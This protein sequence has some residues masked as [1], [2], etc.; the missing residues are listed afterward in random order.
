MEN[1]FGFHDIM[2]IH[3]E[4]DA[5]KGYERDQR[6]SRSGQ[7]MCYNVN[8]AHTCTFVIY[9]FYIYTFLTSSIFPLQNATDSPGES[10]QSHGENTWCITYVYDYYSF[11]CGQGVKLE[12]GC[13]KSR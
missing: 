8:T 1:G 12:S 11:G 10:L 9:M 3:S 6:A 5:T 7:L 4:G 2:H 13:G